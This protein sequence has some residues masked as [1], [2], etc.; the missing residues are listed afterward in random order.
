MLL[1]ALKQHQTLTS[2]LYVTQIGYFRL[3]YY[4]YI[5][6]YIKCIPW[7]RIG[8]SVTKYFLSVQFLFS[9]RLMHVV[10]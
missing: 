3:K 8:L 4:F 6:I 2:R 5:Y 1:T 9:S 7:S 10:F